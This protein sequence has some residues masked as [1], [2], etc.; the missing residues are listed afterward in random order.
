MSDT[1]PDSSKRD[2]GM[3]L[4][5]PREP[6]RLSLILLDGAQIR[7]QNTRVRANMGVRIEDPVAVA[8]HHLPPR[9]SPK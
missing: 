9:W 5:P 4:A 1:S 3:I 6:Y 7:R 2:S 8:R